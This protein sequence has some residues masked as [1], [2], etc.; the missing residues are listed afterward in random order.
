MNPLVPT[1]LN[2][3]RSTKLVKD[4]VGEMNSLCG[5]VACKE[6]PTNAPFSMRQVLLVSPSQPENVRSSKRRSGVPANGFC[7]RVAPTSKVRMKEMSETCFIAFVPRLCNGG[8]QACR[9]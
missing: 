3:K 4:L 9:A 6:P 1:N 7:M 8:G 2:F 5:T